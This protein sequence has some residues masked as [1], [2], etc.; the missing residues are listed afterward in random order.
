MKVRN[1]FSTSVRQVDS[2]WA[3]VDIICVAHVWWWAS[4]TALTW[5]FRPSGRVLPDKPGF[6]LVVA[7]RW[8][9]EEIM[10]RT[11]DLAKYTCKCGSPLPAMIVDC[12]LQRDGGTALRRKVVPTREALAWLGVDL[13]CLVLTALEC[14]RR[15]GD[16]S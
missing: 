1:L 13:A 2:S 11:H 12:S 14:A 8:S 7:K 15:P 5:H 16:Q 9:S 3:L 4:R 10:T 6:L